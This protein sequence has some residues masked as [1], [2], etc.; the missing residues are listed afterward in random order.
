MV[1]IHLTNVIH[2]VLTS[3]RTVVARS[4]QGSYWPE[5]LRTDAVRTH[6]VRNKVLLSTYI[7]PI[8]AVLCAIA[9]VVTPLGL[10]DVFESS[11]SKAMSFEYVAD[12]SPFGFATPPPS[13]LPFTRTCQHMHG[14]LSGPVPCP[15]SDTVIIFSWNGSAFLYDLPWGYNSTLPDITREIYSSGTK[16]RTTTVSNYF[17]IRARRYT[18][19]QS[20]Q[21]NNGSTALSLD[22]RSISSLVLDDAIKPVEGL[23]VDAQKGGVGFRNHT[24]PAGLKH[25]ATWNEDILF[26]EP[27]TSCV[28]TNLTLEYTISLGSNDSRS[29]IYSDLSLVDQGG[30]SSLNTAYPY[31][32]HDNAQN[33]PDLRARAYKAAYLNNA[34]TMA[35]FNVTSINS[36]DNSTVAFSYINSS[37]GK[38]FPL[39]IDTTKG[40]SYEN[41]FLSRAFGNYLPFDTFPQLYPNPFNITEENFVDTGK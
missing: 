36:P 30:F 15:Y 25:G 4:L 33:N 12:R 31:Y 24:L 1:A 32:D 3:I 26:V 17:D 14:G 39:P 7:L 5:L 21:V 23:I 34:Y 6:G 29:T 38:R 20:S 13:D 40:A 41:L 22:Y 10:Y 11:G 27:E 18:F 8:C 28:D 19:T 2:L 35:Y 9:G 16:G 37:R